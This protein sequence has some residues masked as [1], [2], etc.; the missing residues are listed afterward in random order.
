LRF[1]AFRRPG[2][3]SATRRSRSTRIGLTGARSLA[4]PCA[5]LG[6]FWFEEPVPADDLAGLRL[7][8]DRAPAGL[9]IAAGEYGCD[10]PYSECML[11]AQT[12]D[13]LQLDATRCAG[14]SEM[15]P[16]SL[17]P[18]TRRFEL[19]LK[20]LDG[21][22]I[23]GHFWL[24]IGSLTNEAFTDTITDGGAGQCQPPAIAPCPVRSY[25]NPAGQSATIID[26]A[27]F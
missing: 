7:L 27:A 1:P 8:R 4:E 12:F 11:G 26:L 3:R 10:L 14:I 23:N 25:T 15:L 13:V 24:F 9:D 19:S 5:E 21:R 2:R 6:V 18:S 17:G 22:A 20:M 16:G